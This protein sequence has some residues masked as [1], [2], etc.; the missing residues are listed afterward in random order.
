MKE[1]EQNPVHTNTN[2][3]D[4]ERFQIGIHNLLQQMSLPI[5]D[6][7]TSIEERRIAVNNL[8]TVV[9][10]LPDEVLKRSQYISKMA[11]ATSVGLFDA[12]LNYIWN[13]LINELR[14]RIAGFDLAYFFDI[15]AGEDSRLRKKLKN[16]DDLL[17]IDDAHLLRAAMKIGILTD[18][19]FTRLDHIRFMRNHASAAHPNQN[20]ISGLD[21]ANYLQIC[22]REVINREPDTIAVDVSR[23]LANIKNNLLN[24]DEVE[25][26]AAFF[27]KLSPERA[28]T[29]ANG[30]YGLYTA[31]KPTTITVD[32][33]RLL[34]PKLWPYVDEATRQNYGLRHA[35]AVA[36]ADTST[37]Q[38]AHDLLDLAENGSSYLTPES[39]ALDIREAIDTLSS[40]HRGLNNFYNEYAPA[41]RLLSLIDPSGKVPNSVRRDYVQIVIECFLGNGYGVSNAAE[42]LYQDMIQRFSSQD[43]RNA[44]GTCLDPI[45]SSILGTNTGKEQWKKILDILE[46]KMTNH[47]D[48]DLINAL[49]EFPETPDKLRLDSKIKR[50]FDSLPS[51]NSYQNQ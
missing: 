25:R 21:L 34:W 7:F 39:L 28:S 37:A 40:V 20:T 19:G 13:E 15:V 33:V 32:N 29:L 41:T 8:P 14:V 47:F 44:L 36:I 51:L 9:N 16:E 3:A 1:I 24:A 18:V 23:L 46:P 6:L 11:A 10:E 12:A 50:L 43:A 38:A 48:R 49:R 17:L 5:N 22:I 42:P 4:L 35:R 2:A 45:F 26:T 27:S 31:P 30:L